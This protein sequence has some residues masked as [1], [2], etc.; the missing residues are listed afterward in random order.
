MGF[1]MP[2]EQARAFQI[3]GDGGKDRLSTGGGSL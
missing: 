3:D 2:T 1:E